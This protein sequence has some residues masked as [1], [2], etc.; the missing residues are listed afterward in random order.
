MELANGNPAVRIWVVGSS[1]VLGVVQQ[2]ERFDDLPRNIR[3]LWGA[4][5]D[6]AMWSSYLFGNF[7]VC[8]VSISKPGQ[9]QF[10]T[11]RSGTNL[12]VGPRG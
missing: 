4:Q 7:R 11:L 6:D 9:M 3:Q 12:H 5:G 1:R 10:V 2:H 8:A